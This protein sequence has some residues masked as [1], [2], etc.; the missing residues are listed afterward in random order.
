MYRASAATS[1]D[2]RSRGSSS[3]R[4][5]RLVDGGGRGGGGEGGAGGGDGGDGGGAGLGGGDPNGE[6]AVELKKISAVPSP[7]R[8]SHASPSPLSPAPS[9]SIVALRASA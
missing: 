2:V 7:V 8:Y 1:A 9:A 4:S 5:L 3:S 6:Y